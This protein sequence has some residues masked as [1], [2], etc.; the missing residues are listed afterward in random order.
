MM[1]MVTLTKVYQEW[2]YNEV[3]VRV[4]CESSPDPDRQG[5]NLDFRT[6]MKFPFRNL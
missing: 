5:L 6:C 4:N 3:E 2:D 1:T